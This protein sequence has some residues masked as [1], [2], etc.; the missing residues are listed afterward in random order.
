MK[1][2]VG[3]DV[4]AEEHLREW[5]RDHLVHQ[6]SWISDIASALEDWLNDEEYISV[7][8]SGS[9]GKPKRIKNSKAAIIRSAEKTARYLG[10]KHGQSALNVL[11][12]G[13][14]AGR[15]MIYRALVSG[16]DLT[17]LAPKLDLSQSILSLS[18]EFDFCAMTPLQVETTLDQSP[19]AISKIGSLIIGGAPISAA[20]QERIALLD[21][22]CFATYGMTET[23]TH[24]AMRALN[25]PAPEQ[26][27]TA[28]EGVRFETEDGCLVIYADHIDQAVVKTTD[29]VELM[30]DRSFVWKGRAD[31]VINRGGVKLHP[32]LI[33][34]QLA[35]AL[36]QRFFIGRRGADQVGEEPV[37]IIEG[38]EKDLDD[39]YAV[40]N[41]LPKLWR[42][43]E[44]HFVSRLEK[45][46]SGKII[47]DISR[48]DISTK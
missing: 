7:Q 4:V 25:H 6:E 21:T 37:L 20:L 45:T 44:V 22:M 27:Y 33:E 47:R 26:H 17:C 48:Y 10:L 39:I 3:G 36:S 15:M 19:E 11:P 18:S 13:F 41:R 38:S 5:Y 31:H 46:E 29:I 42:P 16:L 1:L 32:E 12:T 30:S 35:P 34:L 8:T 14:I 40:L 9:T 24:V 43:A 28:I 2:R 23:I